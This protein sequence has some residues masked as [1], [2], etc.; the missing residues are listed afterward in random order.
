MSD[1]NPKKPLKDLPFAPKKGKIY[2]MYGKQFST[3]IIRENLNGLIEDYKN[4]VNKTLSD[5]GVPRP[6]WIEWL[7]N[8]GFPENY[9]Q[10]NEWLDEK[11]VFDKI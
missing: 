6:V 7:R 5:R 9:N 4:I 1:N 2:E 3:Q 10:V 8:F 11:T